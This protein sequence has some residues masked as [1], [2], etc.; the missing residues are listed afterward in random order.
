MWLF[1]GWLLERAVLSLLFITC[2]TWEVTPASP[3]HIHSH[4]I[5]KERVEDGAYVRR[6]HQ[7]NVDGEHRS[8]FDHESIIGIFQSFYTKFVLLLLIYLMMFRIK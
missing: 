2:L 5:N 4:Q 7:H 3:A 6:D 1:G 8:E